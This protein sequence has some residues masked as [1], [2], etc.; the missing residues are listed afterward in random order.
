[1]F[2]HLAPDVVAHGFAWR[3]GPGDA[4]IRDEYVDAA[5][6]FIGGFRRGRDGRGIR[7]IENERIDRAFAGKPGLRLFEQARVNVGNEDLGAGLQQG[8]RRAEPDSPAPAGDEGGAPLRSYFAHIHRAPQSVHAHGPPNASR[9]RSIRN[10]IDRVSGRPLRVRAPADE[11]GNDE[12]H[13]FRRLRENPRRLPAATAPWIAAPTQVGLS[14]SGTCTV[15]PRTSAMTV[16]RNGLLFA[17]PLVR[18]SAR[19]GCRRIGTDL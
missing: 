4:G 11:R 7:D 14:I 3:V 8:F 19:Q 15:C 2:D 6:T 17:S 18:R 1:M 10:S 5:M 16:R 13:T 9:R 12:P